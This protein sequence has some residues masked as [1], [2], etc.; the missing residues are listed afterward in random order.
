MKEQEESNKSYEVQSEGVQ[1][2]GILALR[3]ETERLVNRFR[4][5]LTG[6]II[7]TTYDEETGE[8]RSTELTI[9]EPKANAQGVHFLLNFFES[10][11]NPQTVQGNLINEERYDSIVKEI[12]LGLIQD[13]VNN[14]YLWDINEDEVEPLINNVI[15]TIALFL[16]RPIE[17]KERESY[18]QTIR[19]QETNSISNRGGFPNI[20]QRGGV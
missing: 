3:L 7:E 15:N 13:I 19:H 11:V 17:N 20:L 2:A 5:Y 14:M 4:V 18:N 12:H 6:K 1:D 9:A 16:T 8:P 10:I